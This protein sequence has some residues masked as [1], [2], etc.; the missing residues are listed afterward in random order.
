MQRKAVCSL[1][2]FDGYP[3]ITVLFFKMIP[4]RTEIGSLN[5][6]DRGAPS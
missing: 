6:E 1:L 5:L 4:E 3:V 2:L